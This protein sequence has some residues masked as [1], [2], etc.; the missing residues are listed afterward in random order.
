MSCNNPISINFGDLKDTVNPSFVVSSGSSEPVY[1]WNALTLGKNLQSAMNPV[2]GYFIAGQDGIYL[3]EAGITAQTNNST[4]SGLSHL[5]IT[6]K[7]TN[8][9]S[10]PFTGMGSIMFSSIRGL[11]KIKKTETLRLNMNSDSN[12][13]NLTISGLVTSNYFIVTYICSC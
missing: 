5:I 8:V 11:I 7:D 13:P 12:G 2:L 3:V 4:A 10:S 9:L 1:P 6:H